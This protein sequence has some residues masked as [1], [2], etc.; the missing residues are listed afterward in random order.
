MEAFADPAND[1]VVVAV[2]PRWHLEL[3][4]KALESGK[5]VLVEKP[6]F[7]ALDDYRTAIAARDAGRRVVIV[8]ENDHYKPAAVYLRKLLRR[9]TI[10]DLVFATFSTVANRARAASACAGLIS[11]RLRLE[12]LRG[13]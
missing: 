1:A 10:G 5:H 7:P 13:M 9:G 6:A 4:M 11:P 3:T 12:R 2:P 8:G